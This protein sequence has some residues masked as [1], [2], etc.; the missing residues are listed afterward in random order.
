M[1]RLGVVGTYWIESVAPL[2][3]FAPVRS[4][5]ILSALS[6]VF[7]Q[8]LI[9]ATGNYNFF[10][11]LT[12]TLS[13]S[14][15]DDCFFGSSEC[16]ML[17]SMYSS[18]C[19]NVYSLEGSPWSV[20]CSTVVTYSPHILTTCRRGLFGLKRQGR[21]SQALSRD[22]HNNTYSLHDHLQRLLPL[23]LCLYE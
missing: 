1:L 19:S 11:F 22:C 20:P 23:P 17:A 7:L 14:L 9:I 16:Y 5:R 21:E 15:V 18:Y 13:V 12:I 2:L 6:Q 10:N 8:L 3:F 4:L